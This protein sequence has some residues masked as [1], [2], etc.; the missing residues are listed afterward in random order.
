MG[1]ILTW[2]F[3]IDAFRSKIL[4]VLCCILCYVTI[5]NNDF[6]IDDDFAFYHNQFVQEGIRGIP[7]ILSH[8][9]FNDG[10]LSFD[11]RPVAGISFA[12]E[13][14]LFGNNP[15]EAHAT[16]LLLYI[17]C[18]L[19]VFGVLTDVFGLDVL[20]AFLITLF[21]AVHPAHVEVVASIKNREE[22]FSCLFALLSFRFL[23]KLFLQKSISRQILYGAL[24][25]IF[26]LLS[27]ASKL[28]SLP[29]IA[30]MP[31][32][33]YFKGFHRRKV[34]SYSTYGLILLVTAIYFMVIYSLQNR[35]IFDLENPLVNFPGDLSLKIGTAASSLLFYFRF[36]C[37]PYPFSFYYGYNTIPLAHAG[38][39]VAVLSIFLHLVLFIYGAI[40]YFRKDTAGFFI[41]AY[42]I[43][44]SIYSNMIML[45]TGIVSERALFFPALWFIAA[46]CTFIYKKVPVVPVNASLK[47]LAIGFATILIVAYGSLDIYRT[48][49][50]HDTISLMSADIGHLDNAT[51]ANY[52]YA[53]VLKNKSEEQSDTAIQNKYLAESK[54]YFYNAWA[55]S[56]AYPYAYFRLGLIYRYDNYRPDSA[57][58]FFKQAYT[59]NP[60]LTDVAYQYGRAEYEFGD[61]KLSSDIFTKLYQRIPGDTFTVFYHALLLLKTGHPAEGHQ[62]NAVFMTMAPGY[63]QAYFNEGLYYQLMGDS[64]NAASNYEAAIKL[65]CTDPVVYHYLLDFYQQRGNT[66]QAGKFLRLLQ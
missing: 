22:I 55:I 32:F 12:I 42:F 2:D 45:Y 52:F 30:I 48:A 26:L 53:C 4:L 43:A 28:T 8:P 40:L 7:D 56:P 5:V 41:I 38:D 66:A 23:H 19:C 64:V 59:L 65:G 62:I 16:N 35:P 49:Q 36:M 54:K 60:N 1:K 14:E 15:H 24:V 50:W 13:K 33:I 27:F 51:L 61:M 18:V 47:K 29:M 46:C 31:V 21:F 39:P 6:A 9:Y 10:N 34:L 57:Y 20:I 17:L 11:Y 63:Y 25:I 37:L 3:T 44:I 58:I